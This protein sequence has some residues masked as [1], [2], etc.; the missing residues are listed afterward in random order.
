MSDEP[1]QRNA[2]FDA[3]RIILI[4]MTGIGKTTTGRPLADILGMDFL[5]SDE[6]IRRLSGTTPSDLYSAQ[7]EAYFRRLECGVIA[8]LSLRP[9]IVL[10]TG[11][12]AILCPTVQELL[13]K[14]GLVIYLRGSLDAL[15]QR[16]ER[17]QSRPILQSNN[18]VALL[19]RRQQERE[20]IYIESTHIIVDCD[21]HSASDNSHHIA[22][23]IKQFINTH[24]ME[25]PHDAA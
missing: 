7:G 24:H 19:E 20:R 6:E 23:Q 3:S 10:A 16:L 9:A 5:D 22:Q 25:S 18:F 11:G 21:L 4:G 12:G 15:Q 1:A 2:P 17:Q 13:K 14:R 8:D